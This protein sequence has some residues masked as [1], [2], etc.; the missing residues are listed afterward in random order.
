MEDGN[1]SEDGSR[2]PAM[3]AEQRA[4]YDAWIAAHGTSEQD[5]NGIDLSAIRRN[6]RLTPTERLR[7][8]QQAVDSLS[9]LQNARFQD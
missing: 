9:V 4:R 2:A 3:T 8:L 1:L 5:D 7:R 6:L